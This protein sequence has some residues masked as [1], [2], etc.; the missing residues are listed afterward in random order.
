[1]N[2]SREIRVLI[3][4]DNRSVRKG[5][6]LQLEA[7]PGIRVIGE[8]AN[9]ADAVDVALAESA[10]VVLMDMQMPGMNGSEATR[11]IL[12]S[13]EGRTAVIVMTSFA[14]DGFIID[15]LD[16]GAVGYLLKSYDSDQLVSAVHGAARGDAVVSARAITPVLRE[17]ARR[18]GGAAGRPT[19][20]RST[21]CRRQSDGWSAC[22]H[23]G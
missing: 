12:A 22:W 13:A 14:A 21:P 9:G 16:A 11:Q 1:M 10:D 15:A 17:F 2:S 6:R 23:R 4:D 19:P 18:R 20:R 5:L 3:A 8:V 7:G